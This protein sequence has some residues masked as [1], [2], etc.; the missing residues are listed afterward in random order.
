MNSAQ[1]TKRA[2]NVVFQV[3]IQSWIGKHARPSHKSSSAAQQ[4]LGLPEFVEVRCWSPKVRII[5]FLLWTLSTRYLYFIFVV[6]F[7]QHGTQCRVYLLYSSFDHLLI[8]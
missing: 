8:P 1:E 7:H 4:N 3:Y 5:D 6:S 2:D